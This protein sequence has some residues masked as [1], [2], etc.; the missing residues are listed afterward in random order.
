MLHYFFLKVSR[1]LYM[2][3][4]QIFCFNHYQ[5][6]SLNLDESKFIACDEVKDLKQSKR[7]F[8]CCVVKTSVLGNLNITH[9]DILKCCLSGYH[10]NN[11][12]KILFWIYWYSGYIDTFPSNNTWESAVIAQKHPHHFYPPYHMKNRRKGRGWG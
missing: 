6:I 11:S 1:F 4:L 10:L 3:K 12:I 9:S 7:E 5:I 8:P 2:L